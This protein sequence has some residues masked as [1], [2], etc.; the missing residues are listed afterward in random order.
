MASPA[1]QLVKVEPSILVWARESMGLSHSDVAKKIKKDEETIVNWES[2]ELLPTFSQ[3]EKLAYQIYKR[4]LVVFFLPEP[5]KETTIKEDFRTI[6]DEDISALS[7]D[8]RL[9]IRKAKHH[10]VAL[11]EIYLNKNPAEQQIHKDLAFRV[12]LNIAQATKKVREYLKIGFDFKK[13]VSDAATAF[14]S[15]RNILQENGIFVFQYPLKSVR[16]FSLTDKE[17][18]VIVV[19]SSDSP[20]AKNFTLFHELC[21]ILF[22][23]GGI[24]RDFI[25]EELTMGLNKIEKFCNEFASEFLVPASEMAKQFI[26]NKQDNNQAWDEEKIRNVAA[27]FKVSK[28]VILRR[29]LD[30]HL[31]DKY[32][33]SQMTKRWNEQ[34]RILKENRKKQ[35]GGP[36]YQTLVISHLGKKYVSEILDSYH[37]GKLDVRRAA[38]F[39]GVKVNQV[40][41]IED[42][43]Y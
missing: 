34:Y 6:P 5:P 23:T 40:S 26:L 21:H 27:L 35:D 32:Q 42:K 13:S 29:L 36:P 12:E 25:K 2:G 33:Y 41:K 43:I 37:T 31:T 18:P 17:F 19:N 10:Q 30:L 1:N 38:N 20:T 8:V 4:P 16:G 39:L 14:T 3:L 9:V 11:K 22:N 7:P 15:Y 24:F 28:E